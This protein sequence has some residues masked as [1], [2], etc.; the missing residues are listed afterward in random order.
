[1]ACHEMIWEV[2]QVAFIMHGAYQLPLL[3]KTFNFDEYL[4]KT[5][6]EDPKQRVKMVKPVFLE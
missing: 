1:M 6:L 2:T 5:I 4:T 3:F